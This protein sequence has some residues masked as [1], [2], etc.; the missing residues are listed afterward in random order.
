MEERH[1]LWRLH[2]LACPGQT[3]CLVLGEWIDGWTDGQMAGCRTSSS[4]QTNSTVIS[5][6][7]LSF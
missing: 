5:V 3:Q 1:N 4:S 7:L 6:H 2:S